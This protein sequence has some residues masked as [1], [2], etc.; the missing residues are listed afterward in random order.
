MVLDEGDTHPRPQCFRNRPSFADDVRNKTVNFVFNSGLDLAMRYTFS[1]ANLST[2][3][4]DH[5][6]L[7][8]P[9]TEY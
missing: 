1:K 8:C 2:S 5:D 6:Y 3:V 7:K 4:I 9:F